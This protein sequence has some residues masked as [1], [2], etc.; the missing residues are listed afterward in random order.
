MDEALVHSQA[1]FDASLQD[2]EGEEF[3]LG[4]HRSVDVVPGH[5]KTEQERRILFQ[6]VPSDGSIDLGATWA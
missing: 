2:A 4:W 6:V 3:T 1:G 5:R